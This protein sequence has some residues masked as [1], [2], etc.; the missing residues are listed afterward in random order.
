[1]SMERRLFSLLSEKITDLIQNSVEESV[2]RLI[3]TLP[4]SAISGE[5]RSATPSPVDEENNEPAVVEQ[6]QNRHRVLP[7]IG[8]PGSHRSN[9]SDLLTRPDKVVHILNGWNIK[10][11]GSGVLVDNLRR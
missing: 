7:N 1:V 10:F 3:R 2:Q 11:S 6:I 4:N 5:E 8:S 9:M